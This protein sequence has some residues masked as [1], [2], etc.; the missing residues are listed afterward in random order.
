MLSFLIGT[1]KC[2]E[3]DVENK[4]QLP[5]LDA[6][7]LLGDVQYLCAA[8]IMNGFIQ[9]GSEASVCIPV[10]STELPHSVSLKSPVG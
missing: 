4:I 5:E 2:T 10:R 3:E 9:T 1:K 8:F 6:K 7:K